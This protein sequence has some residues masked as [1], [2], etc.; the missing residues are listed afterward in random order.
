[1]LVPGHILRLPSRLRL[2]D[3]SRLSRLRAMCRGTAEFSAVLSFPIRKSS[4]RKAMYKIQC[5]LFPMAQ[6]KRTACS[7][8][9]VS[10][11][12]QEIK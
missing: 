10:L 5:S 1:M 9:S 8:H 12:G 6:W 3:V 7:S 2:V 4:A 11:Y